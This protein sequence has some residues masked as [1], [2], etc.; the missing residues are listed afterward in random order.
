M[1]LLNPYRFGVAIPPDPFY[2]NVVTL[3][4]F[5]GADGSTTFTDDTGLHTYSHVGSAQ[6]DTAQSK[7][8]GSS[9][10]FIAS[11]SSSI[12]TAD[13]ADWDLEGGDFSIQ[14]WYRPASIGTRQF[15]CGQGTATPDYRNVLEI[16]AAGKFQ[17]LTG[18]TPGT[19]LTVLGTTT[20]VAGN[21]YFLEATKSGNDWYVF[22]D[23]N[24]DTTVNNATVF[25]GLA[26]QFSIGA[27][28]TFGSLKLDGHL[29]EFRIT[30]G[31]A[32]NT[33][34]YTPPTTAFP[35]S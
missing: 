35:R 7:F 9:G 19:S 5:N 6:I 33:T 21:W 14:T 4:G 26:G 27:L 10:L 16:T 1:I 3:L 18:A 8:G 23:G 20:L 31:V 25:G 28:G 15:I 13:S 17:Y 32:R 22:V 34:G 29:D 24:L 30:K 2:A 11:G 12:G